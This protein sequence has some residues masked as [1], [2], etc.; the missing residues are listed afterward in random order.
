M[1][2]ALRVLNYKLSLAVNPE[3]N[4][5][6]CL[7][8]LIHEVGRFPLE[9]SEGVEGDHCLLHSMILRGLDDWR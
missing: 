9:G 3:H 4:R 5:P 6:T 8:H 1:L 7:L 2:E